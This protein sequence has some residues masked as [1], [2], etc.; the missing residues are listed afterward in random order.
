ME[1][2]E[3]G[4]PVEG[5]F[6]LL[7]QACAP[8]WKRM[9]ARSFQNPRPVEYGEAGGRILMGGGSDTDGRGSYTNRRPVLPEPAPRWRR[10]GEGQTRTGGGRTRMGVAPSRTRARSG[11]T[12]RPVGTHP[13]PGRDIPRTGVRVP[14]GSLFTTSSPWWRHDYHARRRRPFLD[15]DGVGPDRDTVALSPAFCPPRRRR[16]RPQRRRCPPRR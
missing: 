13:A 5:E 2:E 16:C 1:G 7:G 4:A 11:H 8:R 15:V 12:L 14:V 10:T 3:P 9:G 6:V